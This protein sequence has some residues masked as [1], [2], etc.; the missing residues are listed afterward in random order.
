MSGRKVSRKARAVLVLLVLTMLAPL[1]A[2]CWD[3]RFLDRMGIVFAVAVDDDLSGKHKY[4]VTV[5]VVLPQNVTGG[6]GG[7][8]GQPVT[9][10]TETGDTLFEA[11]R[12]MTAMTSRRL[13]FSHTQLLIIGE[14]AA[15]KGIW[16]LLD[17]IDRNP[18][19]RTGILLLIAKGGRAEKLLE[20]TTMMEQIP[21]QQIRYAVNTNESAWS[22]VYE[23]TAQDVIRDAVHNWKQSAIPAITLSGEAD[24]GN[25]R[26]NVDKI[27]PDVVPRLTTMGILRDGKLIGYMTPKESR[28]L[29]WMYGKFKNTIVKVG[30]PAAD[31]PGNLIVEILS[32]RV[33]IHARKKAGKELPEI[34][35]DLHAQGSISE[36]NCPDVN[37]MNEQTFKDVSRLTEQAVRQEIEQTINKLQQKF[38]SDALGWSTVIYKDQAKTW[39]KLQDDWVSYFPQ[40]PHR[41]EIEIDVTGAGLRAKSIVK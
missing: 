18:E 23:V 14:Q 32:N 31:T 19:V 17:L 9:T 28:G 38:K 7:G 24:A 15:R 37:V 5:Q 26:G 11:L 34:V 2:G 30:C 20:T 10:F 40:T 22:Q 6:I 27:K 35:I 4:K 12:K 39:K 33:R 1:L 36:I 16:P 3:I 41:M 25:D 29:S 8:Q 21:V 13:Y